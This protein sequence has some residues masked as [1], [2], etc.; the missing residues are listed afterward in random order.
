MKIYQITDK[1]IKA[2][3]AAIDRNPVHGMEGGG[4]TV[5]NN[6]ELEAHNKAHR[7]Y[8]YQVVNWVQEISKGETG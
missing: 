1:D 3:L 4:S 6:A 2:L 7:F 5:L 8:N